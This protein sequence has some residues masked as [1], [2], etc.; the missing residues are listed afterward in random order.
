MTVHKPGYIGLVEGGQ[1]PTNMM[2]LEDRR[3]FLDL[4][5]WSQ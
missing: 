5:W 4:K 3:G 1:L 2:L